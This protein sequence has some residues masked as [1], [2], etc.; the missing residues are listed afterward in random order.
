ME[1]EVHED[2]LSITPKLI[3][4]REGAQKVDYSGAQVWKVSTKKTGTRATI[5]RL[6]RRNRKYLLLYIIHFQKIYVFLYLIK[7]SLQ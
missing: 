2:T 5:G 3:E 7:Y 1:T 4:P 6:R